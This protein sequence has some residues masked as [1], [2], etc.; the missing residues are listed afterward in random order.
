M[1]AYSASFRPTW[2]ILTSYAWNI[3]KTGDRDEF[4]ANNNCT[5]F[6]VC[7]GAILQILRCSKPLESKTNTKSVKRIISSDSFKVD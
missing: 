5:E 2:Y 1:Y 4:I 3:S 7:S 6:C